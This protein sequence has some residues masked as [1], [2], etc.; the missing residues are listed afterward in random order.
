[1]TG[2]G[3]IATYELIN[4]E[5]CRFSEVS[6]LVLETILLMKNELIY[7]CFYR[8]HIKI[9]EN[10]QELIGNEIPYFSSFLKTQVFSKVAAAS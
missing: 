1:M 10:S 4:M 5:M 2:S 9:S 6:I 8:S 7:R 3:S